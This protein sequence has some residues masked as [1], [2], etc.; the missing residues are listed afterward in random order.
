MVVLPATPGLL[1]TVVAMTFVFVVPGL[2]ILNLAGGRW[3]IPELLLFS[4]FLGMMQAALVAVLPLLLHLQLVYV[5][6]PHVIISSAI[7][8]ASLRRPGL[9][10]ASDRAGVACLAVLGLAAVALSVT[11]GDQLYRDRDN[12]RVAPY[13]ASYAAGEEMNAENPN[14]GNGVDTTARRVFNVHGVDQALLA[15]FGEVDV[16][17]LVF[18]HFHILSTFL[19]F[20]AV[21]ALGARFGGSRAGLFAVFFLAILAITDLQAQEG[22]G[23]GLLLRPGEDKFFASFVLFPAYLL[24]ALAYSGRTIDKALL[25]L[26]G[27]SLML[28]HPFGPVFIAVALSALVVATWWDQGPAAAGDRRLAGVLLGRQ[29]RDVLKASALTLFVATLPAIYQRFFIDDEA[30]DLFSGEN[31]FRLEVRRIEL[32]L[33]LV[34]LDVS[35]LTHPLL[36]IAIAVAPFVIWRLRRGKRREAAF[37]ALAMIG[38]PVALF[39]PITATI[40]AKLG[41]PGLLWR[42]LYILPFMPVLGVFFARLAIRTRYQLM[43]VAATGAVSVLLLEGMARVNDEAYDLDEAATG[44]S[45]VLSGIDNAWDSNNYWARLRHD[46]ARE[47]IHEIDR[48]IDGAALILIE[49]NIF[50]LGRL[51]TQPFPLDLAVPVYAP[52]VKSYT[53]GPFVTLEDGYDY[54]DVDS[55]RFLDP[56]L[57][58]GRAGGRERAAFATFFFNGRRTINID[59]DDVFVADYGRFFEEKPITHVLVES[60]RLSPVTALPF[61]PPFSIP[62]ASRLDSDV[63]AQESVFRFITT[64][65]GYNL[66]EVLRRASD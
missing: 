44:E 34:S 27:L 8:H 40:L 42:F 31:Q 21:Y 54:S 46:S 12:W 58:E 56:L 61:M 2:A 50:G 64:I 17:D 52:E 65:G 37:V 13:V 32:P 26:G 14:T 63:Q 55:E 51:P 19:A 53:A 57:G 59:G 39:F 3:T 45:V 60:S 9:A 43:A 25:S 29:L 6:V 35:V 18:D 22:Y 24:L 11:S 33:N 4:V 47:F 15:E 10:L 28:M 38:M 23:R 41:S 30:D 66:Y 5:A 20:V 48:A 49:P 16:V 36:W 62:V 7:I 1:A